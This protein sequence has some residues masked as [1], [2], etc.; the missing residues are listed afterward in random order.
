MAGRVIFHGHLGRIYQGDRD[1]GVGT[2]MGLYTGRGSAKTMWLAPDGTSLVDRTLN[3]LRNGESGE[4]HAYRLLL[5]YG[6]PRRECLEPGPAYVQRAL[7][8]GPFRRVR[9]RGNHRY[10][11][12][13]GGHKRRLELRGVIGEGLPYPRLTDVQ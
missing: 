2:G 9:H 12:V 1:G 11:F 5:S 7:A 6:A 13:A 3:K 4:D 8:D 10:I